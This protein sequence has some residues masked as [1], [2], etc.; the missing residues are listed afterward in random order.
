M[1]CLTQTVGSVNSQLITEF[2]YVLND[3][4]I[5]LKKKT[6]VTNV[7]LVLFKFHCLLLI[8]YV[9]ALVSNIQTGPLNL[10]RLIHFESERLTTC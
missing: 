3:Q 7:L 1:W 9:K 10:V 2:L 5:K 8:S 4:E 6:T